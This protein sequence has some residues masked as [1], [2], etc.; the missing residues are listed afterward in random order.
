MKKFMKG[1]YIFI[2]IF[3][4][5]F[6][7]ACSCSNSDKDEIN[8][9][10]QKYV[11]SIVI[12]NSFYTDEFFVD[13]DINLQLYDVTINF[14][15]N[16]SLIFKLGDVYRDKLD[17]S[18]I[19]Q[20]TFKISYLSQ[21]F[22]FNYEVKNIYIKSAT[23]KQDNIVVFDGEQDCLD[24]INFTILYS[25]GVEENHKLKDASVEV[26]WSGEYNTPAVAEVT[27][28]NF[29]FTFDCVVKIREIVL[30]EI[31]ELEDKLGM[32][33]NN[34][35]VLIAQKN[36]ETVATFFHLS[37]ENLVKDWEVSVILQSDGKYEAIVIFEGLKT[38]KI[39][40]Y[41]DKVIIEERQV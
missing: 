1:L 29:Q 16:T 12:E 23:V 8:P 21:E 5:V 41:K 25:N 35:Y 9:D 26:N 31:Y 28:E 34:E 36:A 7:V 6:L 38:V 11:T 33:E 22:T 3:A 17:T 24:D 10:N 14:S 37:G 20:K 4:G 32:F 39:Y 40:A 18:S 27:Y 30:D 13:E 19:G 15:D 2:L